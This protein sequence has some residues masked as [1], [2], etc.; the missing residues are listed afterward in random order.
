[1]IYNGEKMVSQLI[2]K[3]LKTYWSKIFLQTAGAW[4]INGGRFMFNFDYQHK[5][6]CFKYFEAQWG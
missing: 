4:L 5:V 2:R 6:I 1:V 3:D